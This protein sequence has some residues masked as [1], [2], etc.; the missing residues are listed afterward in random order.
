[1]NQT[2]HGVAPDTGV[3]RSAAVEAGQGYRVIS[4]KLTS[5][6]TTA[7]LAWETDATP[8]G[9][10]ISYALHLAEITSTSWDGRPDPYGTQA[11]AAARQCVT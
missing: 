11:L 5:G 2:Y 1:M 3:L 7:W 6:Q 4:T 10:E 8:I 9:V